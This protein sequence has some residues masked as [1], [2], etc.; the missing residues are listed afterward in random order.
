MAEAMS[1][2]ASSTLLPEVSAA[3]ALSWMALEIAG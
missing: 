3:Y 1:F 2:V